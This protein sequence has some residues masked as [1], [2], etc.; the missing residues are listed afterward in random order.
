MG[1]LLHLLKTQRVILIDPS[2]KK[3]LKLGK[4]PQNNSFYVRREFLPFTQPIPNL[5]R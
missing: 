4:P 5:Y 1:Y 2:P 3:E